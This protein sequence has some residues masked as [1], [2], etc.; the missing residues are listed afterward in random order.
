MNLAQLIHSRLIKLNSKI[1]LGKNLRQNKKS[2]TSVQINEYTV[3]GVRSI[4]MVNGTVF[5]DGK[6]VPDTN[7]KNINITITGDLSE[8]TIDYCGD[9]TING[10]VTNIKSSS[11]NVV[12]GDVSGSIN[13]MSGSVDC[14]NV[15]GDVVTMSG[16][17]KRD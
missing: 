13:T 7:V 3:D 16:N 5:V 9:V 6:E 2:I 4:S 10:N 8:F 12:C 14:K 1:T 11:G 17:I 15:N